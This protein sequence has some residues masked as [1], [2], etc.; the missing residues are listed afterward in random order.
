MQW[1]ESNVDENVKRIEKK[2]LN[3]PLRLDL[4]QSVNSDKTHTKSCSDLP[5]TLLSNSH[6]SDLRAS[7]G[8]MI[9]KGLENHSFAHLNNPIV[10]DLSLPHLQSPSNQ[11]HME[12]SKKKLDSSQTRAIIQPG[13]IS[14]SPT[15]SPSL[16]CS[17][18]ER[19][20]SLYH[21][22]YVLSESDRLSHPFLFSMR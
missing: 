21:N 7:T 1:N 2:L 11:F 10:S 14:D 17:P 22:P 20:S 9:H 8:Q 12:C 3:R 15:E 19:H 13:S 4:R 16:P 6:S 5:T 18:A